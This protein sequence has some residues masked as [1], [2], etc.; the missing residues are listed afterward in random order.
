LHRRQPLDVAI[1]SPLKHFYHRL[2]QE[3]FE[4]NHWTV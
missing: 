3:M 2:L 1:F 4:T